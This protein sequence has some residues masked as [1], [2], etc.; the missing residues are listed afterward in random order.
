V[1]GTDEII[2][3]AGG[4]LF[5]CVIKGK[6]RMAETLLARGAD[7]NANVYTS[8]TPLFKAY[9]QKK[10]AF[11]K[12]LERHGGFLDAVSAGFARQTEA[13]K[14]LLADEAAGRLR[15]GAVTPGGTVAEDLLSTAA[16]GGDAEVVRLALERIDWPRQDSRWLYPLW[17]AFTCD[18]G[19]RRGLACFRLLL[20]RADPNLSDSGRTMLHTVVARGEKKHLP[21]AR[22]L[23]DGGARM[24][25][26]D[27]L[28]KSTALGW[29]CRWGRLHFV[30][31]LLA[32]GAD[33]VE[34]DADRWATPSAWAQK[35]K[36]DKVVEKL[37]QPGR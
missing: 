27:D 15:P 13:A 8:G 16:G 33:P 36:H 6:R 35:M 30:K 32:R 23:L 37:R 29:A 9:D 3:S 10:R 2:F 17:Q 19:V 28:L 34:A 25:I 22:M 26:R 7:P 1:G 24:D 5:C 14:Q 20:T 18:G 12:L 4:P 11:V 21:Y 31:L